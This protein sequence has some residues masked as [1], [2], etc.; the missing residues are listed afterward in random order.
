MKYYRKITLK[1]GREC[2]LRN[3]TEADAQEVLDCFILTHEQTDWLLT[4]PDEN[5]FTVEEE[6]RFLKDRTESPDEIEIIAEVDG[7]VAGTAGILRLGTAHK[8]RHRA[9]F[10]I[11]V[12]QKYWRLGIGRALIR[13]CIEC[14]RSAGYRQIELDV[15]AENENAARLYQSEGF[16]EYGR[17]PRGFNSRLTGWQEIIMMRMELNG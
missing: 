12:D 3:G 13:A 10:G 8:I 2:V 9:E 15:T 11:S 6:A 4:Y 17:N 1:D 5:T 7:H 16:V 14:A